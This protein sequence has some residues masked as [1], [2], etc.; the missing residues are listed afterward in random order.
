MIGFLYCI[1]YS[2]CVH[3][4]QHKIAINIGINAQSYKAI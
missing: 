1:Q 3:I 4:C 2:I